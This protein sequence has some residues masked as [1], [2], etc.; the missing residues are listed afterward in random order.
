VLEAAKVGEARLFIL[1]IDDPEAS[2]RP[3]SW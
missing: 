2:S 3:P 1:A